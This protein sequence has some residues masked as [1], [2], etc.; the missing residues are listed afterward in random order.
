MDQ[1][2]VQATQWFLFDENKVWIR[3]ELLMNVVKQKNCPEPSYAFIVSPFQMK[4]EE[5]KLSGIFHNTGC[6]V[7]K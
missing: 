4:G 1:A 2:V 5:L 6:L 3:T 7:I